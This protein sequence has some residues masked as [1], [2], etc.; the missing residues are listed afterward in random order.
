M[1]E[2]ESAG[3]AAIA[4]APVKSSVTMTEDDID[5]LLRKKDGKIYRERHPQL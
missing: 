2:N 4:A 1:K 3:G 5:Q